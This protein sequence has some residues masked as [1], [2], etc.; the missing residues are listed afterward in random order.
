[1]L[2]HVTVKY[3]KIQ[4]RRHSCECCQHYPRKKRTILKEE[5]IA[6][7]WRGGRSKLQRFEAVCYRF[8]VSRRDENAKIIPQSVP[9]Y[10]RR[11]NNAV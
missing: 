2:E 5:I 6:E 4:D 1:M 8:N 11:V 10:A 9:R 7:V 3:A